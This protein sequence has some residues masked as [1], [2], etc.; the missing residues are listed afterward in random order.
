MFM[1]ESYVGH[2]LC[3]PGDLVINSLWAW[4]TGFGF[5]RH[6][7][8]VSSAYGVY[9]LV[10]NLAQD[11]EFFHHLLRSRVYDWEFTV[12]SKG[13]WT[14]RLQLTD[15]SFFDMPI[16]LPPSEDRKAIVR[17][18]RHLDHRV[19]RLIKAKR[20]L[21]EALNEQKQAIIHRAVTRGLDPT[22]PLKP[23]GIP[24]LGDLPQHWEGLQVRRLVSFVTSGS[25]GWANYYS[26]DGLIFLQS[27]NL[28][29]S[30]SL[31]LSYIQH[32]HPPDGAEGERTLVK[33]NDVL[34]CVTGALTGNVAIVDLELPAAAFVNQHVALV[35]PK[36]EMIE[37]RFLAY[38]LH[39][40]IGRSQFKTNEYGGTKQGLGLDD[41]KSVFIP[42]PSLPQQRAIC[43]Y[44]DTKV[45]GFK[46]A[47]SRLERE[48]DLIREYRTRL[49]SDVVTGQLDVR[50][51]DLPEAGAGEE[52]VVGLADEDTGDGEGGDE[53]EMGEGEVGEG[54]EVGDDE[55]EGEAR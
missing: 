45:A 20:K 34:V 24:W 9:R 17:S 14:S 53:G 30:M 37:P 21:I 18:I 39:S 29:R 51:L 48:I 13:I 25:R 49:V 40:E 55:G 16:L 8:I 35:R 4:A 41:V 33:K 2:K 19:N 47:V 42:V 23:S 3:W 32:V 1:A 28:G 6:H 5:A 27:G 46:E 22:V 38:V 26:D 12:R 7:G 43:A 15:E 50:H 44:L 10:P 54:G 11:F 52:P 36:P 31:N